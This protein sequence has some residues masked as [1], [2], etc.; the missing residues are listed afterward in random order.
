MFPGVL[1]ECAMS[2]RCGRLFSP[3]LRVPYCV[4]NMVQP[5]NFTVGCQIRR[6]LL[7]I[8][9]GKSVQERGGGGKALLVLWALGLHRNKAIFK[10]RLASVDSVVDDMDSFVV[11]WFRRARVGEVETSMV[12]LVS[13]K[14]TSYKFQRITGLG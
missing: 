2:T 14:D 4:D 9:Q 10:G 11:W 6:G 1:A 13:Y 5:E 7:R 12:V 8:S 3:V